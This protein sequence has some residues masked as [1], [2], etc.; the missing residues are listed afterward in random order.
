L[1]LGVTTN[2]PSALDEMTDTIEGVQVD[3]VGMV[4]IWKKKRGKTVEKL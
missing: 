3:G 4:N 1:T 2:A